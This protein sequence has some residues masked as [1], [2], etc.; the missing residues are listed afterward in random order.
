MFKIKS[1]AVRA[2]TFLPSGQFVD[3]YLPSGYWRK[4]G[5]SELYGKPAVKVRRPAPLLD[6]G[7]WY[8]APNA[9]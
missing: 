6:M 1:G 4:V 2:A 7:V 8:V 5:P 3:S 9:F